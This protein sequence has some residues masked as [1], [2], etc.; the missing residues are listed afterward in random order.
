[1]VN[2]ESERKK[3]PPTELTD[4]PIVK[5]IPQTYL[6][7]RLGVACSWSLMDEH[8]V[9]VSDRKHH[10]QLHLVRTSQF[11]WIHLLEHECGKAI[12][13]N[14]CV[15]ICRMNHFSCHLHVKALWY[16]SHK[17]SFVWLELVFPDKLSLNLC[18][19]S[20]VFEES[21]LLYTW[22][23]VSQTLVEV[24]CQVCS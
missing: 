22:V 24:G 1:M 9:D 13:V 4:K 19:D 3:K 2:L 10:Y 8:H 14:H 5:P 17:L 21:A 18:L 7:S 16:Q 15:P 23:E 6:K 20:A 11:Q 12:C